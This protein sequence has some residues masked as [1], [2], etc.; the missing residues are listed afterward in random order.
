MEYM[1]NFWNFGKWPSWF[2]SRAWRPMGLLFV[3]FV[4]VRCC[5]GPD[6]LHFLDWFQ[7]YR[8]QLPIYLCRWHPRL[9]ARLPSCQSFVTPL[10]EL[11]PGRNETIRKI[12]WLEQR[13]PRST[14]KLQW[15]NNRD[16]TKCYQGSF[17]AGIQ[18]QMSCNTPVNG[19]DFLL[20]IYR[21]Y[22]CIEIQTSNFEI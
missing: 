21:K 15:L 4:Y 10:F 12:D 11:A 7:S 2:S 3:V 14:T 22:T 19:H 13:K 18:G 17:K 8:R 5:V 1:S 6:F 20:L 9:A 16:F